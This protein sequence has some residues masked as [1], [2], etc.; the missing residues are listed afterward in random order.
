MA[1]FTEPLNVD[2]LDRRLALRIELAV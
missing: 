2:S 1:V